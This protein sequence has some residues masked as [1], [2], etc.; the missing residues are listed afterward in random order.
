MPTL[1]DWV[2]VLVIG[3]L[4][5]ISP[6]P[7]LA[8]ILRNSLVYSRRAGVYTA[9]GLA[10]GNLIHATYC[11]IGIGVIITQSILLFN[12]VKYLGA[13]YLIYI[14]IKSLQAQKHTDT[15][16]TQPVARAMS[17]TVAV[18]TGFLTNLLNP[19]VTLFFLAL[20]TQI[21]RPATPLPAQVVYGLTMVELEF[22]WFAL[23]AVLIS[24]SAIKDRFL[25]ISHWIERTTGVVLIALGIRVALSRNSH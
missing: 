11:L 23:V 2:T 20:F 3:C 8:I 10:A 21:I 12:T 25:A 17:R 18:R 9:L 7:N 16:T 1:T 13:A 5:V 19:K 15:P 22:G 24:Q 6:G 14:G 4:A